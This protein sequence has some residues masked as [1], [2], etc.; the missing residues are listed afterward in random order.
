MRNCKIIL[1]GIETVQFKLLLSGKT[2]NVV[3][4]GLKAQ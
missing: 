4:N 2:N 3:I 1:K